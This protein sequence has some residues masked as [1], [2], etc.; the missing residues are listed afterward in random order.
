MTN[1]NAIRNYLG[2]V[3]LIILFCALIRIIGGQ[4]RLII[5]YFLVPIGLF[6]AYETP[7]SLTLISAAGLTLLFL[8]GRSAWRP[9][10]W[11]FGIIFAALAVTP[12]FFKKMFVKDEKEFDGRK[13]FLSNTAENLKTELTSVEEDSKHLQNEVEKITRLYLLGREFVEQMDM[14]EI[15]EHLK[16]SIFDKPEIKSVAIFALDKR[17]ITPIYL[18]LPDD[19]SSWTAFV[20]DCQQLIN[21]QRGPSV[22]P[23]GPFGNKSVILWPVKIEEDITVAVF[24]VTSSDFTDQCIEEGKIFIPQI[25]LGFKRIRLFEEVREKSRRDGLTGL[26]LRRY[27]IERLEGEIHRAK[28]YSASFSLLMADIDRFKNINDVYGHLVGD[29]ALKAL[30]QLLTDS[31][32][33]GDLIGRYGGEEFIIL[34]PLTTLDEAT[35]IA[36]RLV[37][38]IAKKDFL[39]NYRHFNMTLSV[40]ISHYP[41]DGGNTQ[42]LI[43]AS[44]KALYWV[45]THGRNGVKDFKGIQK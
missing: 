26:Y 25:A 2:S 42:K 29:S 27:F 45:K 1:K 44:D 32:R 10:G 13:N 30:S 17:N 18:S 28:R 12:F 36:T 34:L 4:I 5:I 16:I 14:K 6:L 7:Y 20:N 37:K 24:L 41:S 35:K 43:E 31:L 38:I 23:S 3:F 19:I 21:S 33:P 8:F 22:I 40:G 39:G 15:I 11:M 9:D